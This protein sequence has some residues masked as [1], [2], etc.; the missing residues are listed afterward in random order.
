MTSENAM[1][2]Y[3]QMNEIVYPEMMSLIFNVAKGDM[4]LDLLKDITNKF[5]LLSQLPKAL[6]MENGRDKEE[7]M[8]NI[9]E[10]L[11]RVM[12]L[13]S[14]NRDDDT[15]VAMQLRNAMYA[16][17][18]IRQITLNYTSTIENNQEVTSDGQGV[19]ESK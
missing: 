10:L 9:D 11:G 17:D 19:E 14:R 5:D 1:I 15:A 8:L 18:R 6:E 13:L 3:K 2:I 7:L 12:K 4:F 16:M